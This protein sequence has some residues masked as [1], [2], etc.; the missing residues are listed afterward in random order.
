VN[1]SAEVKRVLGF[2]QR[3]AFPLGAALTSFGAAYL[4]LAY[5]V[6]NFW[7]YV[8]HYELSWAEQLNEYLLFKARSQW[9]YP[10]LALSVFCVSVGIVLLMFRCSRVHYKIWEVKGDK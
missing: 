5:H 3:R 7:T 4:I 1:W 6:L 9:E 8:P 10:L 2:L